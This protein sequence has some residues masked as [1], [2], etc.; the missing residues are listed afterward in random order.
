MELIN[1]KLP[2]ALQTVNL[3][4]TNSSGLTEAGLWPLVLPSVSDW[5]DYPDLSAV[6]LSTTLILHLVDII[7]ES[8]TQK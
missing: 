4:D 2:K 6:R 3:P 5:A 8:T 1:R 7:T